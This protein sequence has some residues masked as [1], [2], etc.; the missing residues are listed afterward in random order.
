MFPRNDTSMVRS[1]KLLSVNI[2]GSE[3]KRPTVV[4]VSTSASQGVQALH[5]YCLKL[6]QIPIVSKLATLQMPDILR[7]VHSPL[8]PIV[9]VV[10]NPK[11]SGTSQDYKLH[12]QRLNLTPI[13]KCLPDSLG[14]FKIKS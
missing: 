6:H 2:F 12:G 9:S 8:V 7:S 5:L 3:V 4:L 13:P 14:R 10:K 1:K 11:C